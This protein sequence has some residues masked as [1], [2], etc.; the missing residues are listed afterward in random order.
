[1]VIVKGDN[2]RLHWLQVASLVLATCI[3]WIF[4][5]GLINSQKSLALWGSWLYLGVVT[6]ALIVEVVMPVLRGKVY[7]VYQ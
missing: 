2:K 3:G 4:G 6:V 5:F 1:V 7:K